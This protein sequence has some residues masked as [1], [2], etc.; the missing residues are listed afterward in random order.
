MFESWKVKQGK[1]SNLVS[2]FCVKK[3]RDKTTF[4]W[5]NKLWYK[6]G[7]HDYL[8]LWDSSRVSISKTF[9]FAT[10][11]KNWV[12]FQKV[13]QLVPSKTIFLFFPT[14]N[15]SEF[16]LKKTTNFSFYVRKNMSDRFKFTQ[17]LFASMD[18]I[19]IG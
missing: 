19:K 16:T 10:E 17:I 9:F 1:K 6:F 3:R 14:Y 7:S 12:F 13:F 2:G 18:R 5:D 11:K 15:N 8:S 4:V